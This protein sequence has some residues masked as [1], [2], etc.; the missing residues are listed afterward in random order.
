MSFFDRKTESVKVSG[1]FFRHFDRKCQDVRKN[2]A[3]LDDSWFWSASIFWAA[4]G[5]FVKAFLLFSHKIF[6][7][8]FFINLL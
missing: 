7:I 3:L 6:K 2:A 5:N 4:H 1:I 8:N